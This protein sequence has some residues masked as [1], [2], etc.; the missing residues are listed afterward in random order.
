MRFAWLHRS[1]AD[2]PP[3]K[4]GCGISLSRMVYNA[5]WWIPVLLALAGTISYGAGFIGFAIVTMLRLVANLVVNNVLTVEQAGT[6][7]FRA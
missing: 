5:V 3:V 4:L 6:F 2:K 1:T 7:P